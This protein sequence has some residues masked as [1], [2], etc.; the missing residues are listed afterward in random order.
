[1][2]VLLHSAGSITQT[3]RA[4]YIGDANG[5]LPLLPTEAAQ[6]KQCICC[7]RLVHR[8]TQPVAFKNKNLFTESGRNIKEYS[9]AKQGL[10]Q[11]ASSKWS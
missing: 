11:Q 4:K 8:R 7:F 2:Y 1:M 3:G 6:G 5:I 10:P 9:T